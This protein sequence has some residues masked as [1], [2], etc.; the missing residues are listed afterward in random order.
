MS[1]KTM[2]ES[3]EMWDRKKKEGKKGRKE[4]SQGVEKELERVKAKKKMRRKESYRIEKTDYWVVAS[5]E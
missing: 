2:D 5:W 3:G 1:Q 4:L